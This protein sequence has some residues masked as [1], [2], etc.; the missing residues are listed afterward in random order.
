MAV[1]AAIAIL[2]ACGKP[3]PSKADVMQ[4]D[5]GQI[6]K[7]IRDFRTR[8]GRPPRTLKELG[9]IPNDP[10]TGKADWRVVTEQAVRVD[11]FS[12]APATPAPP[13][14]VDVRSNAQGTDPNG[15][16]WSEY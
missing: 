10:V 14:I 9:A 12:G 5:L 7:A 6:R 4:H 1:A 15:R 13:G 16:P 3:Q 2:A 8:T 11:D